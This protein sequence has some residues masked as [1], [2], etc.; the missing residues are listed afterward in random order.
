MNSLEDTSIIQRFIQSHNSWGLRFHENKNE[1]H[2]ITSIQAIQQ[3]PYKN[4]SIEENAVLTI[5]SKNKDTVLQ[6][7]GKSNSMVIV[8]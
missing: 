2:V 6:K 4:L 5:S 7:S 1:G 8:K 3:K